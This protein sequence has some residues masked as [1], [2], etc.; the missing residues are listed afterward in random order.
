MRAVKEL[1]PL[2]M[3]ELWAFLCLLGQTDFFY[4]L[5]AGVHLSFLLL[6][7][8]MP[9]SGYMDSLSKSEEIAGTY[10][11]RPFIQSII[12]KIPWIL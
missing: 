7:R 4:C 8:R 2:G 3:S 1:W 12:S 10:V 11:D 9:T 6:H 5:T